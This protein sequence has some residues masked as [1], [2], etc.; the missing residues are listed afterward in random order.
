MSKQ[1]VT[2]RS[3]VRW[4]Y[5][6]DRK[7]RLVDLWCAASRVG[8]VWSYEVGDRLPD[9]LPYYVLTS[10]IPD[11]ATVAEG[12]LPVSVVPCAPSMT[13]KIRGCVSG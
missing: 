8:S 5:R 6:D 12:A 7:I 2:R 10:Q 13:P 3:E 4:P 1:R 11:T 9:H